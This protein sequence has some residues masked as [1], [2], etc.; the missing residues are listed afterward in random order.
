M[1]R[2]LRKGAPRA[3]LLKL[4]EEVKAKESEAGSEKRT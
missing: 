2:T 3:L 4:Q 1:A